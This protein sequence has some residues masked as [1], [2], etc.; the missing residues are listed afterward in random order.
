MQRAWEGWVAKGAIS[1]EA[2]EAARKVAEWVASNN[3]SSD[4]GRES[5]GANISSDSELLAPWLT[6]V[7]G[8]NA[9]ALLGL[10]NPLQ[11]K[12]QLG[13]ALQLLSGVCPATVE[14]QEQVLM[15]H[16]RVHAACGD[17]RGLAGMCVASV[18]TPSAS[19][20]TSFYTLFSIA[21][22]PVSAINPWALQSAG[23]SAIK[24]ATAMGGDAP[25]EANLPVMLGTLAS[26]IILTGAARQEAAAAAA[27]GDD[28]KEGPGQQQQPQVGIPTVLHDPVALAAL[29]ALVCHWQAPEQQGALEQVLGEDALLELQ[30]CAETTGD[31]SLGQVPQLTGVTSVNLAAWAQYIRS[32]GATSGSSEGSTSGGSSSTA[33]VSWASMSP[34][35]RKQVQRAALEVLVRGCA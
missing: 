16:A 9:C 29:H 25:L 17:W 20:P 31:T 12:Q 33:R 5:I 24:A 14:G 32:S 2:V 18:V 8:A 7:A 19:T 22:L 11:A 1:T 35:A 4:S 23:S 27:T 34:E 6:T 13:N 10:Q 28:N 21:G 26:S 30:A 3:S 15:A